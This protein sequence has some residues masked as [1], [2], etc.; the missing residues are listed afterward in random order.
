MVI[1]G[2]VDDHTRSLGLLEEAV[3]ATLAV[4]GLFPCPRLQGIRASL[5][6]VV[7]FT[8]TATATWR[9]NTS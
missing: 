3:T 4:F 5:M 2:A 8:R 1:D 7:F 9:R 6:P